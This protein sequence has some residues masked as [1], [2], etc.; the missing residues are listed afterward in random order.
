[1]PWAAGG[2]TDL[3][4]GLLLCRHHHRQVHEGGWTIH[5]ITPD[6]GAHGTL[7]FTSP[8]GTHFPSPVPTAHGPSP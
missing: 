2:P 1:M 5:A 4:N 8:T 6:Q 7:H 3:T